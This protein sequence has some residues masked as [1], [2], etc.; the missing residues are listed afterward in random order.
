VLPLLATSALAGAGSQGDLSSSSLLA[1]G[2]SQIEAGLTALSLERGH[3][4]SPASVDGNASRLDVTVQSSDGFSVLGIYGNY[5]PS[6]NETTAHVA[7]VFRATPHEEDYAVFLYPTEGQGSDVRITALNVALAPAAGD[8][9]QQPH[10]FITQTGT[11]CVPL[12]AS[13]A[14]QALAP[15]SAI[16]VSGHFR[17][18]FWGW[19]IDVDGAGGPKHYDSGLEKKAVAGNPPV[20]DRNVNDVTARLVTLEVSGGT[21]SLSTPPSALDGFA[22]HGTQ[23]STRGALLLQDVQGLA[24]SRSPSLRIEGEPAMAVATDGDRLLIHLQNPRGL[25][26]LDAASGRAIPVFGPA[27]STSIAAP[28]LAFGGAVAAALAVAAVLV[29]RRARRPRRGLE[30]LMAALDSRDYASATRVA[31]GMLVEGAAGDIA[32]LKTIALLKS[33][34][35]RQ[36]R[37]FLEAQPSSVKPEPAAYWYLMACCQALEGSLQD[38]LACLRRCLEEDPAYETEARLNPWLVAVLHRIVDRPAA[39]HGP[40][41][42]T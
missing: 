19:G 4:F 10:F 37:E 15:D 39:H 17:A 7:A 22:I 23:M 25:S 26:F 3:L 9:L 31:D 14:I 27:A 28:G 29:V 5:L 40:E 18:A 16:Q 33:G 35:P 11:R 20:A 1:T 34:K 36:A 8:C 6:T 21:L 2:V 30:G 32:V 41:G 42:Y 12:A 13:Q 38:S 24:N